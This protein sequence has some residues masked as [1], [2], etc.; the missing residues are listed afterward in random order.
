MVDIT[1]ND[2]FNLEKLN[3]NS[4]YYAGGTIYLYRGLNGENY[5]LKKFHFT[6]PDSEYELE[7]EENDNFFHT[8]NLLM[9]N[10]SIINIPELVMPVDTF[11]ID[12]IP[13]GFI[14]E[15]INGK[16][17]DF[18]L[19]DFNTSS[20]V[21]KSYL[22]QVGNILRKMKTA[23]ENLNGDFF[24]GDMHEK[25]FI[26]EDRSDLVRVVDL[27]S[28]KLLDNKPCQSKFLFLNKEIWNMPDKYPV[29]EEN[30]DITM[31]SENTDLLCYHMMILNYIAN[32]EVYDLSTKEFY[33]YLEYLKKCGVGL[34]LL[35][36]FNRL[37]SNEDN[38]N[39]MN[40]IDEIPD[41][42][43]RASYKVFE[44]LRKK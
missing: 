13:V 25:N 30:N 43:G 29:Y 23:R 4:E 3:N 36:S 15:V 14:S 33:N 12:T 18:I 17:L 35:E 32:C 38:T 24:L 20:T 2:F 7:S 40:F 21:K 10:K 27:D 19:N 22:K 42:I 34:N 5:A 39:P 1:S 16:R 26:V 6:Y 9:K 37:Y 44:Y 11:S 41:D 28:S 31:P 8:V